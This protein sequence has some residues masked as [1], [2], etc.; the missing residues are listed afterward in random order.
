MKTRMR[1]QPRDHCRASRRQ[2]TKSSNWRRMRW[3][4]ARGPMKRMIYG[5]QRAASMRC[6]WGTTIAGRTAPTK[7]MHLSGHATELLELSW[8]LQSGQHCM[9]ALPGIDISTGFVVTAAP[10]LAGTMATEMTIRAVRIAR[11]KNMPGKYWA[12][13][14]GG[15]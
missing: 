4:N 8:S 9:S 6:G 13:S 11:M 3:R 14:A 7:L 10:P 15:Q 5:R 2:P 12:R 1:A